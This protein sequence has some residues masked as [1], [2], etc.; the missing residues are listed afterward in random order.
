MTTFLLIHGAYQGGWIWQQVADR[1]QAAGHRVLCPSLDG[2]AERAH[3]LRPGITTESQAAELVELLRFHDLSDVVLAGTS[4][5]G[6]VMARVAEQAR[7]RVGRLVFADALSLFHGESIAD[8]VS[9]PTAV[10]SELA[11][12]PTREDSEQRL[13]AE[14]EPD[15][16]A[17]TSQRFTPHPIAIFTEPVE[18]EQFWEAVVEH[19]RALLFG[20]RQSWRGPHPPHGR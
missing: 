7:E 10:T 3:Q 18:L 15:L 11:T 19:I 16:R 9:R 13:L 17:W 14:L 5:G 6:M 8:I 2:C 1:I 20:R 12:G 4:S